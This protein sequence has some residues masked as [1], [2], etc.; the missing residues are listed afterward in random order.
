MATYQM[1]ILHQASVPNR[2]GPKQP[3]SC[4]CMAQGMP[5]QDSYV[6]ANA[7]Q[8]LVTIVIPNFNH[9]PYLAAAIQ[10]VL[11]Q[12]YANV[13]IVVV[14]DGS[15]DNSR[16]VAASFAD[17]IKIIHQVNRG[18]SEARNSGIRAAQG[19]YIGLLDADDMLEPDYLKT[20]TTMLSTTP[21]AHGVICGYRFV[22]EQNRPLPQI[23]S[24]R[25]QEDELY[26]LLLRG[27]FLVPESI[28]LHR[29]CY[30]DVGPFDPSL[31][32]CE[33]WDMWLSVTK[34]FRI[35]S[36]DQILTRHRVLPESM[37]SSPKRMLENR[38]TV[39]LKHVGAEPTA[40]E[41]DNQMVRHCY[42][43][44]YLTSAVEHLQ[45]GDEFKAIEY[46]HR[47]SW[48][49]PEILTRLD[50]FYELGLGNQPKGQRGYLRE[51][52]LATNSAGVMR[53]LTTLLS[54]E[55]G[56]G[57]TTKQQRRIYAA[58]YNALSML[59]YGAGDMRLSRR[60]LM[61]LIMSR[62]GSIFE[63]HYLAKVI[64]SL[65]GKHALQ[66]FKSRSIKAWHVSE[67]GWRGSR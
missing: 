7:G 32:A 50:T 49:Y 10:S 58:A 46:L 65:V 60:Y 39:L 30:E 27:N 13:E 61:R 43:Q 62:P 57:L 29:Q 44:G 5:Q 54:P 9:A 37:S 40:I 26:P 25:L 4:A 31:S 28:L 24:R 3:T 51:L 52:D 2:L 8:P 23:E 56:L 41:P 15:T 47:A 55:S 20:L 45:V 33:D 22:D 14:D 66:W 6:L 53:M 63:R 35:I 36:T 59:A 64:G 12:T 67:N 42:S 19:T 1:S 21:S 34:K 16:D 38:L 18:L 17:Q 48:L 11:D